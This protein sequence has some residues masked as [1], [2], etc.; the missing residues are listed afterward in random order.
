MKQP[1]TGQLYLVKKNLKG[2][3]RPLKRRGDDALAITCRKLYRDPWLLATSLPH[4]H[5]TAK[6]IE[7]IYGLRMQIEE[8]FR[9]IKNGRW[10]PGMEYAR[11]VNQERLEN[12][13]LIGTLGTFVPWLNGVVVKAKGWAKHFQANT[14]KR[15][16][17]LSLLFLGKRLLNDKRFK[18]GRR[19]M[20]T[21]FKD[22][23]IMIQ[24]Q[25]NF[26]GIS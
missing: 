12:L 5:G 26:V 16:T 11:S 24:K 25:V 21:A 7:K 6:R 22:I 20:A 23:S 17:V 19:D 8:T 2:R 15:H 10:G 9:D 4:A 18:Y 14:E 13:L 3:K 1:Y